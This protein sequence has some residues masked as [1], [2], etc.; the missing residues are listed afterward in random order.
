MVEAIRYVDLVI[1]EE[2]MAQ[3]VEDIKEHK[4][5]IFTLGDDYKETFKLYDEHDKVAELCEI[6][7]LSRTPEIS[8]TKIKDGL[9]I[10]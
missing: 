8:T 5:D 9:N 3:K 2:S 6:V 10:R 1:P 7:Y 4:V